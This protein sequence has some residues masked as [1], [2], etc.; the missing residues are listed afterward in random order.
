MR[1][2][3]EGWVGRCCREVPVCSTCAQDVVRCMRRALLVQAEKGVSYCQFNPCS[4][5]RAKEPA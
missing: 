1:V 3:E 2:E 4:K 5:L